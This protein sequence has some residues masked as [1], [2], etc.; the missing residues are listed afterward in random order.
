M[1]QYKKKDKCENHERFITFVMFHL[2]NADISITECVSLR[3]L[4][5]RDSSVVSTPVLCLATQLCPIFV[6][7]WT[8]ACQ[9]PPP[10]GIN[11]GHTGVWKVQQIKAKEHALSSYQANPVDTPQAVTKKTN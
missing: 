11:R 1:L 3:S 10:T 9:T 2:E 8:K 7:A 6:T 4:G 5:Q